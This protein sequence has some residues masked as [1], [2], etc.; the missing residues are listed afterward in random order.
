MISILSLLVC[1]FFLPSYA[2]QQSLEGDWVGTL[3][4]KDKEERVDVH[5]K[6][7]Q[8]EIKGTI[9]FPLKEQMNLALSKINSVAPRVSLEWQD[10]GG[11]IVFNGQLSDGTISGEVRQGESQGTLALVR[12]AK[13]D[14]KIY[15]EYA[16]VYEVSPNK[17]IT[18]ARFPPGPVYIDYESGRTGALSPLSDNTL[19]GGPAFILPAPIDIRITLVRNGSGE[20]NKL[21]FDQEGAPEKRARKI[22]FKSE[23]VTFKNRNVTLSGTLTLPNTKA[24]FPAGIRIHGAGPASRRNTVVADQVSAYHGTAS[25]SYDK[26]GV[27]QSTGDWRTSSFEDLAGDTL[28]AVQYLKSRPDI[29]PKRISIGAG[30][31][32]GWVAAIVATRSRDV[33]SI[34]LVACPAVSYVDEVMLEVEDILRIRGGFSG[35]ELEQAL[36]FQKLVL[37]MART[38]EAL[39]DEGWERLEAAAQK[40]RNE[41]WYRYV[42][43]DPRDNYWWRRAP[44][45]ANFDPVPLWEKIRIPV[46]AVYG[47]LDRNAPAPKN[48]ANLEKALR[49]AGNRDYLIKV[50]PKANHELMEAKTGFLSESLYLKR[51]VPGFFDIFDE[52][53]LR[54][55]NSRK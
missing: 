29:N 3:R 49:K 9:D 48:A 23:E 4:L 52:W 45:I 51:Y 14:P 42:E 6:T 36:A 41:K 22:K 35:K 47:E 18:I 21:I 31:E 16:G 33:A 19:F 20:V 39:T 25:L 32:G 26:R 53:K 50:F 37:D 55:V 43:P 1:G 28:A 2:A 13:V 10:Q 11:T 34:T 15:D 8:G 24:R 54:R 17:L 5:F 44:L 27:G 30:S 7:E 12:V 40:V 38:G 46:L